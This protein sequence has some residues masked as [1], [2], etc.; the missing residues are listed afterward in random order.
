[1]FGVDIWCVHCEWLQQET[2]T[3]A[4]QVVCSSDNFILFSELGQSPK[5]TSTPDLRSKVWDVDN[6]CQG[7]GGKGGGF[8][9]RPFDFCPVEVRHV[10]YNVK[11]EFDR[12]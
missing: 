4:Q 12:Y 10:H 5:Q 9:D 11:I 8:E 2:T 6:G 3:T 1:M 7:R